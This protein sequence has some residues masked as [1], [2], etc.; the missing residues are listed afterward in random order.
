[1]KFFNRA[2]GEMFDNITDAELAYCQRRMA[3]KRDCRTCPL[4][5]DNNRTGM[6]CNKF[7]FNFPE[8]AAEIMRYDI[9]KD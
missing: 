1:M 8:K 9:M 3:N 4:A 2:T 6:G 5:A 7:C